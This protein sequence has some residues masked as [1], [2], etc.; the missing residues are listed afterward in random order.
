MPDPRERPDMMPD[1]MPIPAPSIAMIRDDD[2]RA[3]A[4]I[5]AEALARRIP[6]ANL[7]ADLALE[8]WRA[9]QKAG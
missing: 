6:L 7:L 3:A 4:A 2:L 1:L 8:G 9:R 5:R